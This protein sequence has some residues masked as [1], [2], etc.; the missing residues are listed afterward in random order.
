MQMSAQSVCSN[1][2]LVDRLRTG[3]HKALYSSC[4][5]GQL[6]LLK[7][8]G[9]ATVSDTDRAWLPS[10]TR[11]PYVQ[12]MSTKIL[13]RLMDSG[14]NCSP[15]KLSQREGDPVIKGDPPWSHQGRSTLE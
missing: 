8:E 12:G 7:K 2:F 10:K 9:T 3:Q 14:K 11:W 13:Q 4:T 5:P 1:A 15:H 6:C